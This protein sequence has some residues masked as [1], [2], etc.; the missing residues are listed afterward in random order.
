MPAPPKPYS[1]MCSGGDEGTGTAPDGMDPTLNWADPNNQ[2]VDAVSARI[3]LYKDGAQVIKGYADQQKGAC[4]SAQILAAML[5][6][7]KMSFYF[8]P[9]SDS[10]HA[11]T[12]L[13]YLYP[14]NP[15]VPNQQEG[16]TWSDLR[17]VLPRVAKLPPHGMWV[18]LEAWDTLKQNEKPTDYMLTPVTEAPIGDKFALSGIHG[19]IWM[20]YTLTERYQLPRLF[21]PDHSK[22]EDTYQ[23]AVI[24]RKIEQF[25]AT[26][27]CIL[28]WVKGFLAFQKERNG[29]FYLFDRFIKS[30]ASK[31][32]TTLAQWKAECVRLEKFV[33]NIAETRDNSRDL[34]DAKLWVMN[35][36]PQELYDWFEEKIPENI[37][38]TTATIIILTNFS[39]VIDRISMVR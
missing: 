8:Y 6:K 3:F 13:P 19:Q 27:E 23:M 21:Y 30:C 22:T 20:I 34:V 1:E 35:H 14:S 39:H 29:Q 4:Y 12:E 15:R 17:L 7:T 26:F 32:H 31:L 38:D 9:H 36:A 28:S 18:S 16:E 2:R 24:A 10:R 37:P 25:K 5:E 33:G 11:T